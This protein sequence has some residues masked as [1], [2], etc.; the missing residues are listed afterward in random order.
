M[1]DL[2]QGKDIIAESLA[3]MIYLKRINLDMEGCECVQDEV[4]KSFFEALSIM[5]S[6]HTIRINTRSCFQVTSESLKSLEKLAQNPTIKKVDLNFSECEGMTDQGLIYIAGWLRKHTTLE[7]LSLN[8]INCH[9]L[10]DLGMIAL[11]E[12]LKEKKNLKSLSLDFE[13]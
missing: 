4:H 10:T 6:L 8:F 7:D 1:T 3:K 11:A 2:D 9:Q 5:K 12:S 13:R